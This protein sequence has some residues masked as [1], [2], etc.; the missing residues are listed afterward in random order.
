MDTE[1]LVYLQKVKNYLNINNEAKNYFIG[2]SDAEEFYKHLA[3]ISE[4]NF[5]KNGQPELTQ[6]QFELL[7]K[8]ISAITASKQKFFYSSDG[9]FM[10]FEDYP[11]ISMN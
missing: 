1:V 11:P 4:K 7:R 6:E 9:T 3:I 5:E 10:F 8:T 2:N